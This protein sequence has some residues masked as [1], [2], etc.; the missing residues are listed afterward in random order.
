MHAFS[1]QNP[2]TYRKAPLRDGGGA[3]R[4]N[5]KMGTGF[6]SSQKVAP[7]VAPSLRFYSTVIGAHSHR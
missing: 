2:R 4:G 5:R 1:R 3:R 7:Y 6:Y